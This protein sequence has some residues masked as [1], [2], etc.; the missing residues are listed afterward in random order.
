MNSSKAVPTLE[1]RDIRFQYRNNSSDLFSGQSHIFEAGSITALTGASG[2]GK[3]TLLYLLGLMLRPTSGQVFLQGNRVDNA[4]DVIRSKIRA[5]QLGFIFQDASLDPSRTILDSVLEPARFS[6]KPY[7]ANKNRALRL[8]EELGLAHRTNHKP[9]EISGGQAQRVA[10]A[11][12][13]I[14]DPQVILADEPTGN[15]DALNGKAV[16][17]TLEEIAEDG[18]TIIVATHDPVVVS[19]AAYVLTLL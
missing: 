15:L 12:S 14:N 13:L 7:W 10:I 2:R 9:G 17:D 5:S 1:F 3:S 16:L 18:K 4:S 8:L 11:R 19:R 6:M